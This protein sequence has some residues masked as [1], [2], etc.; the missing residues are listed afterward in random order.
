MFRSL[1]RLVNP[2][3]RI[4]PVRF[5]FCQLYRIRS[6]GLPTIMLDT[7]ACL[8]SSFYSFWANFLDVVRENERGFLVLDLHSMRV[9]PDPPPHTSLDQCRAQQRGPSVS[10]GPFRVRRCSPRA[11]PPTAPC[12]I[13]RPG[14]GRRS[15]VI[16]RA[17]VAPPLRPSP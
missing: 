6:K 7:Q 1:R 10:A 16:D 11:R 5:H 13:D 15:S 12:T 8:A 2:D 17:Y 3:A 14:L 9:Q 4:H